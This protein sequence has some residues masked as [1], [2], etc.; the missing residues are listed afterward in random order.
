[1]SS[2]ENSALLGGDLWKKAK[3]ENEKEEKGE[4]E[5]GGARVGKVLS[6]PDRTWTSFAWPPKIDHFSGGQKSLLVQIPA[7][8]EAK[9]SKPDLRFY[10]WLASRWPWLLR[11]QTLVRAVPRTPQQMKQLDDWRQQLLQVVPLFL[12]ENQRSWSRSRSSK[13]WQG[14][15]SPTQSQI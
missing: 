1:M 9:L 15:C 11:R 6:E 14:H 13:W 10:W 4:K 5:W 12:K 7:E 3:E 8:R 2:N